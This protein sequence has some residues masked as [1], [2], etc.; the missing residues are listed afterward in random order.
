MGVG[1]DEARISTVAQEMDGIIHI[2]TLMEDFAEPIRRVVRDT[3]G[4]GRWIEQIDMMSDREMPEA[5]E[6]G[7]MFKNALYVLAI[8]CVVKCRNDRL[9]FLGM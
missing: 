4:C 5:Q 2:I 7:E 1:P 3:E 6:I 8:L 9:I